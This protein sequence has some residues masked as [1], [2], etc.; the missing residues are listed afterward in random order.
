MSISNILNNS[1]AS[2][3]NI[4]LYCKGLRCSETCLCKNLLATEESTFLSKLNVY[5]D[6]RFYSDVQ[7]DGTLTCAGFTGGTGTYNT[8]N[9]VNANL[10]HIN[11]LDITGNTA[12]FSGITATTINTTS[13]IG[14][15]CNMSGVVF[16]GSSLF[17]N[18]TYST[19]LSCGATL[20]CL[21][22]KVNNS[23]TITNNLNVGQS[24]TCQNLQATNNLQSD[25][26]ATFNQS[27]TQYG[28]TDKK[29]VVPRLNTGDRDAIGGEAAALV[30]NTDY[31]DIP[32]LQTYNP[33]NGIWYNISTYPQIAQ[34]FLSG[35]ESV[36]NATLY[37]IGSQTDLKE[38]FNSFPDSSYFA[39]SSPG[40]FKILISGIYKFNMTVAMQ[41]PTN[42]FNTLVMYFYVGESNGANMFNCVGSYDSAGSIH[43]PNKE[44]KYQIEAITPLEAGQVVSFFVYQENDTGNN[45]NINV[46][47]IYAPFYT[48]YNNIFSLQYVSPKI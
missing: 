30:Y 45:F 35:D 38:I 22:L 31:A 48:Q 7:I 9:A 2:P 34:Y 40:E 4:L 42:S 47:N 1:N 36:S 20:T 44:Q 3:A 10:D 43:Y 17:S 27:T 21:N 18:G 25:T 8:I 11:C 37:K 41:A 5:G 33:N 14:T 32:R 39:Y 13:I 16:G 24:I 12:T 28:Y 46:N 26:T 23:G 15:N 6:G 19:G 29:C